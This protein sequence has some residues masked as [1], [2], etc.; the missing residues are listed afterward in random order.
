MRYYVYEPDSNNFYGIG[1]DPESD[2][3]MIDIFYEDEPLA[4]NWKPPVFHGFDDN[5]DQEGDFPSLSNFNELPVMS[6]RAWEALGPLV[7]YCC[8]LLPIIHPSGARY[9]IVHVLETIDCL[10]QERSELRRSKI[11]GRVNRIFRYCFKEEMLH[12]KHIFKL[13]LESGG[14]LLVDDLFRETVESHGLQG[15]LFNELP[16]VK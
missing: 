1:A 4:K 8:E 2:P 14:E 6:E 3:T 9:A 15:L 5:P 10:D 11:D 16:M 13:P 12:L 7:G